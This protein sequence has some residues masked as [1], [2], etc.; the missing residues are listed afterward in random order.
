MAP[1]Q[2][3]RTV[4]KFPLLTM[5]CLEKTVWKWA[6]EKPDSGCQKTQG[7]DFRGKVTSGLW[8]RNAFF[9]VRTARVSVILF[10]LGEREIRE[11]EMF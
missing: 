3:L 6:G 5:I 4:L 2:V 8:R 11:M 1:N 10:L 9:I 7:T